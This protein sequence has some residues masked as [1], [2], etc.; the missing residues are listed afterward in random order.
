LRSIEGSL[1][2]SALADGLMT[3]KKYDFSQTTLLAEAGRNC[4]WTPWLKPTAI[5][6][7]KYLQFAMHPLWRWIPPFCFIPPLVE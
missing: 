7:K 5:R 6:K 1:L 3:K 4:D 2:L